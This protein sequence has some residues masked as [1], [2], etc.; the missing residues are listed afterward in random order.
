VGHIGGEAQNVA[1][2]GNYAYV[3][4]FAHEDNYGNYVG[5]GL[6]VIDVTNPVAPVEVISS[7]CPSN[8]VCF[9][10]YYH[11]ISNGK[12]AMSGRAAYLPAKGRITPNESSYGI[13]VVSLEN[14]TRPQYGAFL[15]IGPAPYS[16]YQVYSLSTF[17]SKLYAKSGVFLDIYDISNPPFPQRL[18]HAIIVGD[19]H[20]RA[21]GNYAYWG[22][23]T[24]V[25]FDVSNPASPRQVGSCSVRGPVR[26]IYVVGSYAYIAWGGGLSVLDVSNPTA[27]REVGVYTPTGW[28]S[29]VSVTVAGNYAYVATGGLRIVD[30]SNPA[31]PREVGSYET[32]GSAQ[33]IYIAGGYVYVAAGDGLF[34]FKM[35]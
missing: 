1:V 14:P 19:G 18:G 20:I 35:R 11:S 3:G 31:N 22:W 21:Y 30:V 34:I 10:W 15:E 12:L 17:S 26:D 25:I 16:N 9:E 2:Q 7:E 13:L 24:L 33:D 23:G 4:V 6:R 29:V 28:P 27:P 32:P 8:F 5:G